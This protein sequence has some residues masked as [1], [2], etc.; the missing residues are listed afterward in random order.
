MGPLTLVR[1]WNARRDPSIPPASSVDTLGCLRNRLGPRRTEGGFVLPSMAIVLLRCIWLTGIHRAQNLITWGLRPPPIRTERLS[2][3]SSRGNCT[4][5]ARLSVSRNKRRRFAPC[6]RCARSGIWSIRGQPEPP[7]RFATYVTREIPP[8][9][10]VVPSNL[11]KSRLVFHKNSDRLPTRETVLGTASLSLDNQ[12]LA[13][14]QPA[15]PA[16][17]SCGTLERAENVLVRRRSPICTFFGQMHPCWISPP[18]HARPAPR[19]PR[20]RAMCSGF[21][22]VNNQC[23]VYPHCVGQNPFDPRRAKRLRRQKQHI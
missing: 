8:S 11:R 1:W 23:C 7:M 15:Q 13:A 20:V 22:I 21:C 4:A 10:C 3:R 19:Q 2:A 18:P 16:P 17:N 9:I 14:W 6:T 5:S 12:T